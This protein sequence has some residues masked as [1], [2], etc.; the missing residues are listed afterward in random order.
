VRGPT[1][2]EFIEDAASGT[3]IKIDVI[4]ALLRDFL[5]SLHEIEFKSKYY[6]GMSCIEQVY[7]PLGPEAA[8]ILWSCSPV[9]AA[10]MIRMILWRC[11]SALTLPCIAT[12][13]RF[14]AGRQR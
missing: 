14:S 5:R 6:S 2:E 8:F 9:V 7:F 10:A 3:D 12:A 13:L 4:R 1:L 11:F